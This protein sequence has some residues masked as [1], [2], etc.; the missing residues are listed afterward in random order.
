[1]KI[2]ILDDAKDNLM[3]GFQMSKLQQIVHEAL[4]RL[5]EACSGCF[6]HNAAAV[7]LLGHGDEAIS[8][9][10]TEVLA[11]AD[12]QRRPRD[13]PSVMV[14]YSQL[15]RRFDS[16]DRA[17]TFL[18]RLPQ[19]FREQAL[20]GACSAWHL[21]FPKPVALPPSVRLYLEEMLQTGGDAGRRTAQR[22]LQRDQDVA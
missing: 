6:V 19:P 9:I 17:V 16:A 20:S 22:I 2:E 12:Q 8:A 15:L 18:Q 3:D 10:E 21:H 11:R 5:R 7:E 4:D 1:M 13:L 14:I